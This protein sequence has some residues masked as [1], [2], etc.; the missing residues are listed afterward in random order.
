MQVQ[1]GDFANVFHQNPQRFHHF[2]HRLPELSFR[3]KQS[4][5]QE[6][7]RSTIFGKK[8]AA[9]SFLQGLQQKTGDTRYQNGRVS[10][11]PLPSLEGMHG[12]CRF[13]YNGCSAMLTSH[14]VTKQASSNPRKPGPL[15]KYISGWEAAYKTSALSVR[16]PACSNTDCLLRVQ[17][18]DR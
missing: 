18:D 4:S 1:F 17:Q 10:P 11:V 5:R 9:A 14:R 16:N 8:L 3:G 6:G 15:L 12:F 7:V 13:R 2:A